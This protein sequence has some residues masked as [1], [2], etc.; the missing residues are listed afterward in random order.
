LKAA[1]AGWYL[2]LK[3]L[4]RKLDDRS[5]AVSDLGRKLIFD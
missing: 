2:E 4:I 1:L 5:A 3:W